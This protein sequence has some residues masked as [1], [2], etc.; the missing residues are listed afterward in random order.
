[1]EL[2]FV[3]EDKNELEFELDNTEIEVEVN[4]DHDKL[5]HRDY[6]NQH[7]ISAI[8]GL[9]EALDNSGKVDDVKVNNQSVVSNKIADIKLKTINN[10]AITGEGNIDGGLVD[11]VKLNN[12]SVVSDKIAN[13]NLK[14]INNQSIVG[15]G[16][17]D[18]GLVDDVKVNGSSVVSN[19][20]ANISV[21]SIEGL[22][23][24]SDVSTAIATH[25]SSNSAHNDIRTEIG[26][27]ED[28]IPAQASSS[29]QLADKNFVNSSIATNTANF[30]GTFNSVADLE[31]Y[32]GTLTNNDYAYVIATDSAGN[33]SYDR[34]KYT[35]ATTPASWEYEYSLN[36]SSFTAAQWAA[37]N[38]GITTSAVTQI[39]TN[40]TNIASKTEKVE[41]V[42]SNTPDQEGFIHSKYTPAELWSLYNQA[43]TLLTVNGQLIADAHLNNA[44][45]FSCA[46]LLAEEKWTPIYVRMYTVR[47]NDDNK[48]RVSADIP[49]A[50]ADFTINGHK[51]SDNMGVMTLTPEDL[52]Y[53]NTIKGTSVTTAKGALDTLT[54][55]VNALSTVEANPTLAGTESDLTALEVDGTKY[56][57][58]S[59]GSGGGNT[60]TIQ[61]SWSTMPQ[62]PNVG[63]RVTNVNDNSGTP[64]GGGGGNTTVVQTS[65]DNMPSNPSVGDR[66]TNLNDISGFKFLQPEIDVTAPI[67]T[68]ITVTDGT[69]TYT[70]TA[71]D[72]LTKFNV[73]DYG[74]WDISLTIEGTTKTKTLKVDAVKVYEVNPRFV[75]SGYQEVEWIGS[76][77]TQYIN[78][79][80]IPTN[81]IEMTATTYKESITD[82]NKLM[83]LGLYQNSNRCYIPSLYTT[84]KMSINYGLIDVSN[85]SYG[86]TAVGKHDLYVHFTTSSQDIEIDGIS[87]YHAT[88]ST[89]ITTDRTLYMFALHNDSGASGFMSYRIYSCQIK[90]NDT[91]VRDFV[92]C[93][94]ISDNERGL[95]DLVNNEF[96]T[97]QG[98]GIFEKGDEV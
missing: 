29:N 4:K 53:V 72:T 83:V 93:Y 82:N 84:N 24:E 77:G 74:D 8:T 31:A 89:T 48:L 12:Q 92:P 57:I 6:A 49:A 73:N 44:G 54:T 41:I 56:K 3:L 32:S 9:Q 45:D 80:V 11:D 7:P 97:N 28:K 39:S 87:I 20:V 85:I 55:N 75:P 59:G 60:T 42:L 34:Y 68:E 1:M 96:Y 22:A 25:N 21:P 33:E 62:N 78:T 17:I 13:I 63:D 65:W 70:K 16:N 76:T 88:A 37:I 38:S 86:Q 2:D 51:L 15:S 46:I 58:P 66:V 79:G 5:N 27:I 90:L 69:T 91:L 95:Y 67:G 43:D 23:S 30:I 18:G 14:T 26:G 98:S 81:D 94:R 47:Y 71:T 19:K 35:T 64:G 40:T 50:S 36:N 52:A 10:Q 61:T